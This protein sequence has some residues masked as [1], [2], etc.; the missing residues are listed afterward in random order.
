MQRVTNARQMQSIDRR[1]IHDFGISGTVL[2]ENAG[3]CVARKIKEIF[4][5]KRAVVLAGGG[6]N[7]GD[8]LV[9]ARHLHNAGWNVKVFLSAPCRKLKGDP[10]VQYEAA[11]KCGVEIAS[12]SEFLEHSS[13]I[14]TSHSVVIDALFG[15]GLKREVTGVFSDA[16]SRVNNTE[17]QVI[18]VDIPSGISSDTGQIMGQAVRADYTVTFGLPKRGHFLYPGAEYTGRLFVED[19]GFPGE[20]MTGSDLNVSLIRRNDILSLLPE[21]PD[22][23]HK[24]TY[25]HVLVVAGSRGKT[26][27]AF[28]TAKACMRSGAGMVTLGIPETL[29]GIFQSV[30]TE[31]M[32]LVLPDAGDGTLSEKSLPVISR[33]L[34]EKA[35]VLAIG[36]GIGVTSGTEKI[37]RDLVKTSPSP[38]IIDADGLNSIK[39]SRLLFR[40]AKSPVILTPHP[41]EMARLCSFSGKAKRTTRKVFRASDIEKDRISIAQVFSEEAGVHLVLKGAPTVIATPEGNV[42]LNTTGNPGM[43]TAGTGD[44]LVGIISGVLGQ[45]KDAVSSCVLAVYLHGF[46]GDMAAS[47]KGTHSLIA[48]DIIEKI[49]AAFCSILQNEEHSIP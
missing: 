4:P 24:G 22:C 17:S 41:G 47:E 19:I 7:G 11:V 6:N 8:G 3:L 27:A 42:Y 18:A 28:M 26:G 43:A 34:E 40:K 30:V 48:S 15:T 9:V 1:T 39:G 33:F 16:M 14:L 38:L 13:S 29:A 21:R 37:I 36:P 45:T 12:F 46:A 44:V 5:G 10:L 49:P 32:V 35:D 25:G 2:M 31:E 23:S 20:L